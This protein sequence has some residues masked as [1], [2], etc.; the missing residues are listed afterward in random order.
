[1]ACNDGDPLRVMPPTI[2]PE[3]PQSGDRLKLLEWS[4]MNSRSPKWMA[5]GLSE[6]EAE[7]KWDSP[8]VMVGLLSHP[9]FEKMKPKP[10]IT[11]IA[12]IL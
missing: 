8:V 6:L 7:Q 11:R 9:S 4:A 2:A 12:T 10:Q 3:S 1:M 5:S